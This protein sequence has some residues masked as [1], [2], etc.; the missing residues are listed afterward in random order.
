MER[1]YPSSGFSVGS[2]LLG[3]ARLAARRIN[4]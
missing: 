4:C 3:V 2:C 1:S